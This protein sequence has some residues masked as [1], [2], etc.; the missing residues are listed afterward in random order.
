MRRDRGLPVLREKELLAAGVDVGP[1]R[2]IT[3][4]LGRAGGGKWHVPWRSAY[5]QWLRHPDASAF[6]PASKKPPCPFASSPANRAEP[7]EPSTIALRR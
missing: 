5:R 2:R 4:V 1:L 3:V 7:T 6:T